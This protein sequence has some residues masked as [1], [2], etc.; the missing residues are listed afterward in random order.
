MRKAKVLID[1]DF[2][3][4]DTDPRLFGAFVETPR[5]VCTAAFMSRVIPG[6]RERLLAG[7]CSR[8]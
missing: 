4:A 2:A 7:M 8:W 5:T 6:G 1:R 3:I